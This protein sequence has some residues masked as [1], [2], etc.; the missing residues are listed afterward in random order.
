MRLPR[1][2]GSFYPDNEHALTQTIKRCFHHKLGPGALPGLKTRNVKAV[3]APHAGYAYSGPAAAWSY[4]ALGETPKPDVYMIIGPNHNSFETAL[5]NDSWQTPLGIARTDSRFVTQL[6]RNANIPINE[7]LHA[8][9]H[10]LEVQLPFLQFVLG[11][12]APALKIAPLILGIDADLKELAL[13]IK[14]VIIDQAKNVFFIISSDFTHYGRFYHYT[15]FTLNVKKNIYELDGKALE[16]IKNLDADGFKNF[17]ESTQ[18][19]I[20]G[21]KPIELLLRLAK[22]LKINKVLVEQYYTSGDITGDYKNSVS[23][24]SV[25]FE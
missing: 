3:I 21:A 1:F 22:S 17:I 16:F 18:A 5:S 8:V 20:C 25:V 23:Y 13:A 19:T 14:E 6:S 4:K 9:E 11:E 2:A 15:P 24:A 12:Q 10:S 7:Q